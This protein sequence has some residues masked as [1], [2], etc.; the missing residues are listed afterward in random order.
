MPFPS[1]IYSKDENYSNKQKGLFLLVIT[2]HL[3][4]IIENLFRVY[5]VQTSTAPLEALIAC[6]PYLFFSRNIQIK[7]SL[8]LF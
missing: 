2:T 3:S 4:L 7:L 1:I 5:N 8:S 6:I